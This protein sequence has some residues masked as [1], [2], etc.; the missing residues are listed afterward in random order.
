ME[1][2]KM[3]CI[4]KNDGCIRYIGSTTNNFKE[5]IGEDGI[6]SY[7]LGK[8]SRTNIKLSDGK[9]L[10]IFTDYCGELQIREGV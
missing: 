3:T 8:N 9:I 1:N 7:Q 10:V 6:I 4:P 5:E 2:V